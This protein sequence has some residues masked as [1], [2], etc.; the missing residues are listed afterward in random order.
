MV[1]NSDGRNNNEQCSC[2]PPLINTTS[3]NSGLHT[4]IACLRNTGKYQP[5][6]LFAGNISYRASQEL[7]LTHCRP[8]MRI[9]F[10]FEPVVICN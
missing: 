7:G 4:T 3:R 9:V 10:G 1:I 6:H 5:Y 2:R 8:F